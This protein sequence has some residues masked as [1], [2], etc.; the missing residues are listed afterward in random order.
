MTLWHAYTRQQKHFLNKKANDMSATQ[1]ISSDYDEEDSESESA[2]DEY[3][4]KRNSILIK[5][6]YLK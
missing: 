5:R 2:S 6:K 3:E 4:N 1:S